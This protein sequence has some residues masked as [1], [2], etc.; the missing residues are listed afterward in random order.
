MAAREYQPQLV[1]GDRA[2]VFLLGRSK[3]VALFGEGKLGHGLLL[4][5][6]RALPSQAVDTA[7]A[8]GGRDPRPGIG[9]D[10]G[11]RPTLDGGQERVLDGLLGKVEVAQDADQRGDRAPMLLAEDAL[12]RC[13]SGVRRGRQ[14][15]AAEVGWPCS[16]AAL[17]ASGNSI[18]GRISIV[19]YFAP[20]HHDAS[21]MASSRSFASKR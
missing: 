13:G 5:G 1:V 16:A 4:A 18:T 17:A 7:V 8:R 11:H 3:V 9:R 2:R 6:E 10:A 14:A 15:V 20:G 21:S 19:P 12:Y